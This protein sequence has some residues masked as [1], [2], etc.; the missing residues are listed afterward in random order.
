METKANIDSLY[1]ESNITK[2]QKQDEISTYQQGLDSTD[3]QQE[4]ESIDVCLEEWVMVDEVADGWRI[5]TP[6]YSHPVSVLDVAAYISKKMGEMTTMKLQKLVYYCQAWSLVWDE[7]PLFEE[8]IE[9]WANGPVVRELYN[10]HRGQYSISS[11]LTGNPDVLNQE[12]KET[13]NAVLEYYG[14]RSSQWLTALTH[15]EDAW[16]IARRGMSGMERGNRVIKLDT[17]AEYYSSLPI[18]D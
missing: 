15:M 11:V 14:D 18:E 10:Y 13:I 17:M 4:A 2:Y 3:Y 9:A 1:D 5:D 8:D 12:Q 6:N 16:R 7:K